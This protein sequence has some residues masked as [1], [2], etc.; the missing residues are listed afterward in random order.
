MRNCLKFIG[1]QCWLQSD[2]PF[3]EWLLM[4]MLPLGC[5]VTMTTLFSLHSMLYK[6]CI[7]TLRA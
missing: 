6:R 4:L 2:E 5:A 1:I 7:R 3:G